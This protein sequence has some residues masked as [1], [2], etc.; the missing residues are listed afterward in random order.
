[1]SDKQVRYDLQWRGTTRP[2]HAMG[3]PNSPSPNFQLSSESNQQLD[4]FVAPVMIN[5]R[6]M[7]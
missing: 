6:E 3:C 1:M 2:W 7:N 4:D 5:E